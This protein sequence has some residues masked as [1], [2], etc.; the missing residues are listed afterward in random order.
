MILRRI[1]VQ[2]F[3]KLVEPVVIENLSDKL[4]IIV[5][6]NEE[7]KST[8]LQ[9]IRSCFF[10]KH[11]MTGERAQSFQPYNSSTRPEVRVEF[12][13]NGKPYKLF[14]AFCYRP[15]AE[16]TTPTGVLLG[17]AAEEELARILRFTSP[18]RASRSAS[19]HEHEGIFGMFWVEQGK[20]YAGLQPTADGRS[21]IQQALQQ[22]VGD[23]LGGKRGQKILAEV[24]NMRNELL[25]NTGRPKGEYAKATNRLSEIRE[26]LATVEVALNDYGRKLEDLER[27]RARQRRYEAER[28]LEHAEERQQRAGESSERIASLQGTLQQAE[29]ELGKTTA[30]HNLAA[31]RAG[32]R[33]RLISE[34]DST[35][36]RVEQLQTT[37]DAKQDSLAK[38]RQQAESREKQLSQAAK[39]FEEA[40]VAHSLAAASEQLARSQAELEKLLARER[41]A[42]QAK[43]KAGHSLEAAS[44][45]GIEKKDIT[46]LK[47]L[48]D[49]VTKAR[50]RIEALATN[51]RIDLEPGVK[52]RI[53]RAAIVSGT[54]YHLTEAS[55][56]DISD[57]AKIKIVPGGDIADPLAESK[58]AQDKLQRA[59]NE[60]GVSKCAEAEARLE[61]R[62]NFLSEANKYEE[63]VDAHAPEGWDVLQNAIA[64]LRG[65]IKRL[66]E[67]VG[68]KPKSLKDSVSAVKDAQ[69]ELDTAAEE[70]KRLERRDKQAREDLAAAQTDEAGCKASFES[71]KHR[72]RELAERLAEE[73]KK[74]S[75]SDLQNAVVEASQR[76]ATA[77]QTAAAARTVLEDADPESAKLELEA[78]GDALKQ[79]V[80]SMRALSDRVIRVETELRA[81]GAQGLG[82]R[83]QQLEGELKGAAA[84]ASTLERRAK[85]VELLHHVLTEAEKKA[86][87]TFLRPV[88]SRIQPYLKLL[89]PGSELQLSEEMDIVGLRR[90]EVDEKFASLSIGT[91]EQ[92]AVLT[93][94]AFA[95]LLRESGQPAAVLLDDAI[96]FADDDRFT[97]MI[98]ILRKASEKTQILVFTCRERDYLAAGAPILRLADCRA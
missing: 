77:E 14:K 20:S 75:D 32:Q 88:T 63:L 33:T 94:L 34:V 80:D 46:R 76:V 13:I 69:R 37:W 2:N 60:L 97:R 25:T 11:N 83:S 27:C 16:L 50:A 18:Q 58:N 45:I 53:G 35:K 73:R 82:E 41:D 86:K 36:R 65:E 55:T 1:A 95:D 68:A 4:V 85:A 24:T 26:E 8:L 49:E 21:T 3:R 71:E 47:H 66:T 81:S 48:N 51:V 74:V 30:E 29:T 23:V 78:A 39:Q 87:E 15:Q 19:D 79:L 10:D 72:L 38:A 52:A 90:G 64:E 89:L 43:A 31:N 91:R 98:H 57:C 44:A 6:D 59:L 56:I 17:S 84:V 61:D 62:Q 70:H 93:R 42:L 7:G 54:D 92:L 22:E 5:G 96:V 40:E 12:E 28:T 9:A 67:Q